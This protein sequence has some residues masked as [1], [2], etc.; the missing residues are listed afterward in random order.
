M[1]IDVQG[2]LLAGFYIVIGYLILRLLG[3]G[4]FW[5]L[6]MVI[7][8]FDM[9]TGGSARREVATKEL[10]IQR[11]IC[12]DEAVAIM[13]H[14]EGYETASHGEVWDKTDSVM[15]ARGILDS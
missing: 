5:I 4:L 10:S 12:E 3:W 8:F 13:L 9:I 15:E 14:C 2:L 11:Q 7:G 6:A 1:Y